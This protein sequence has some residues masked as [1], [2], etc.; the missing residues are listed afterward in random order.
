MILPVYRATLSF[1]FLLM[2]LIPQAV[3]SQS[4]TKPLEISHLAGDFY[5]YV[6]YSDYNGEQVPSNSMYVVTTNGVVLID[7]PWDPAQFQPL[8]DSIQKR[9]NKK[10]VLC[11]AT[12]FHADATAGLEYYSGQGIATYTSA[13]THSLSIQRNE[14]VAQHHFSKDTSFV[15][16]NHSFSTYYPGEGHSPDNIVIWFP[17]DKILYGG[18]FV[19]SSDSTS[20][21][22][23]GDANIPAWEVSVKKTMKQFNSPQFVIPGHLSWR[24]K[25][26]LRHTLSIIRNH[27]KQQ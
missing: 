1:L 8:L 21:G 9:H 16:G 14:K 11:V 23:I 24:G 7:T 19:K 13:H 2:A 6:T 17:A 5:V 20:I 4:K 25:D 18:C 12:H 27:K 22:N 10:V 26:N 3:H 15:V